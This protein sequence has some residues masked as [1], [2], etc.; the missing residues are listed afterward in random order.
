MEEGAQV[1]GDFVDDFLLHMNTIRGLA[2]PA[3][4]SSS[5]APSRYPVALAFSQSDATFRVVFA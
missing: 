2:K 4:A 3:H 1:L 5:S